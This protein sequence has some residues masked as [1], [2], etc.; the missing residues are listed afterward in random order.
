VLDLIEPALWTLSKTEAIDPTSDFWWIDDDPTESD[1]NWLRA[2]NCEHRLLQV[3]ADDD[4]DALRV[5]RS[6][7]LPARSLRPC[8]HKGR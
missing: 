6:R 3:S 8:T 7:I 5:A 2:H 1:R 4:P